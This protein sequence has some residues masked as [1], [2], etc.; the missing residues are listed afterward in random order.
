MDD[1]NDELDLE[2]ADEQINKIMDWVH[3]YIRELSIK[4]CPHARTFLEYPRYIVGPDLGQIMT[5]KAID[6]PPPAS[7]V[8]MVWTDL[9]ASPYSYFAHWIAKQNEQHFGTLLT[10]YHPAD[11]AL[12]P[13]Q[14]EMLKDQGIALITLVAVE[15]YQKAYS[16]PP[17]DLT[18]A[19]TLR[20]CTR[21]AQAK[22]FTPALAQGFRA[23]DE[24]AITSRYDG[25]KH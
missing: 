17:Q 25:V 12:D 22:A 24:R 10:A 5:I 9:G 20:H 18:A 15:D 7:P 23:R 16:R 6:P 1:F 8:V 4:T 19:Q 13:V 21:M 2:P 3:E 11:P 14:A